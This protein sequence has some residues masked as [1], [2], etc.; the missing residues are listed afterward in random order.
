MTVAALYV[1]PGGTYYDLPD[2][3]PWGCRETPLELGACELP[4]RDARLYDG[5][6]PVVAHPP[7]ARWWRY[8]SG[9][10]NPKQKR[11]EL[12]DDDGCFASAIAA[13]RRWGGVLEHPEASHA[14]RHFG[15]AAPPK[16]GGW[17]MAG[18]GQ[19]WTCCFRCSVPV[20]TW[21]YLVKPWAM[22]LPALIW[23]PA[24]GDPSLVI[25]E[26]Y[27]STDERR[28]KLHR[29]GPVGRMGAAER[30]ATP[31]AFRDALLGIPRSCQ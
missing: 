12:G 10:P 1:A 31:P 15:V 2:V 21:V 26:G 27:H 22:P 19:G 6:W 28:R 30:R 7:C 5:P 9:G 17:I 25:D 13:V 14:W 24:K 3:E 29:M 16:R 11:R 8:W 18:D 20:A 23:G 4:D